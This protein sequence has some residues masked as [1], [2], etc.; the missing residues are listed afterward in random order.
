MK[1]EK[2]HVNPFVKFLRIVL[3]VILILVLAFAAFIGYLTATEYLSLFF[4]M[5]P[6]ITACPPIPE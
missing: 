5:I 2:K 3:L 1:T 6:S 4:I